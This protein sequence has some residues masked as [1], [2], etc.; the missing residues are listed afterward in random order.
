MGKN[1]QKHRKRDRR[2]GE[3][4]YDASGKQVDD[5]DTEAGKSLGYKDIVR[6]NKL[7]EEFYKSQGICPEDQWEE[8]MRVLRTDLPASFR[9][10][11]TRSQVKQSLS[12]RRSFYSLFYNA[13]GHPNLDQQLSKYANKLSGMAICKQNCQEQQFATSLSGNNNLPDLKKN[14]NKMQN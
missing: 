4:Q 9:I 1:R 14:R 6:E 13:P 5:R 8:M 2:L 11:G 12:F 10:T 3:L 7:F